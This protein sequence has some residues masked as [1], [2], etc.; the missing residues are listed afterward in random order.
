[1]RPRFRTRISRV[2]L[3]SVASRADHMTPGVS[4][5]VIGLLLQSSTASRGC[6]VVVGP[7]C[8]LDSLYTG[9]AEH[10]RSEFSTELFPTYIIIHCV[11]LRTP[12]ILKTHITQSYESHCRSLSACL[13]TYHGKKLLSAD[14]IFPRGVLRCLI[15]NGVTS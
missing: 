15:G 7:C 5:N 1:M 12:F 3:D 14:S 2:R 10:A 8:E 11:S 4:M 6:N 9:D 13:S